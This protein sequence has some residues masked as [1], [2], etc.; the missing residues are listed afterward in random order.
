M[1][2]EG[3]CEGVAGELS[4]QRKAMWKEKHLLGSGD[5]KCEARH[6][7]Q[8][9]GQGGWSSIN[10]QADEWQWRRAEGRSGQSARQG[11]ERRRKVFA[12]WTAFGGWNQE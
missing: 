8:E 5:S 7:E 6:W 1:V 2:K 9:G 3:L 11:S 12:Q 4:L 10:K